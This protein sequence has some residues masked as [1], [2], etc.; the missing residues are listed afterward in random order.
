MAGPARLDLG[1]A[2]D[3]VPIRVVGEHLPVTAPAGKPALGNDAVYVLEVRV[4]AS[5]RGE[6]LSEI[7]AS[8]AGGL[9]QV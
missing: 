1:E 6:E 5:G 3:L 9:V 4:A 2:I 7:V 8:D